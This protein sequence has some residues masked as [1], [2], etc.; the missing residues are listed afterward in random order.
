MAN[1]SGGTIYVGVTDNGEVVGIDY[2]DV[3]I[4]RIA[5]VARDAIKPDVT[6]FI[7][8]ETIDMDGKQIVSVVVQCGTSRP[9]YL[10]AKGLRPEGVYIRQGT[11]S[12]PASDAAIRRMIVNTDGDNYEDMRSLR[13]DLTF[14]YAESEFAGRKLELGITRMKTLGLIGVDGLY[15]N[16]DLLFSD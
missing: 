3:V 6:M 11:S 9:Y 1:I 12:V 5:N 8:Y 7:N 4:Q 2:P 16:L 10:A 14:K 15:T 13:Q